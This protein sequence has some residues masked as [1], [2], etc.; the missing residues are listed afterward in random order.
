[1][2]FSSIIQ[3]AHALR[4][5]ER[6]SVEI[7]QEYLNR[8][9]A[10][11]SSLN[12]FITVTSEQ[13]LEAARL[14][15]EKRAKGLA[16]WLTGIPIVY[17]DNFC[18]QGVLTTCASRML[19][20][21]I[22]P[23]NAAVVERLKAAGVVILG[24]TNMDEFAM[25]ASNETSFY[26]PVKNPWNI[27]CV[28][29]GSSGGSAAAISAG[30]ATFG[31]GSDTGG[32]IRQP[33]A[34]CNLVGLKPTY[35]RISRYGMIA[36]ASSLDQAGPMTRTAEDAAYVMNVL[37]GVDNQDSTSLNTPVPDY[38]AT[39]NDSL[40]GLTIGVPKEFFEEGL[41]AA[42]AQRM[43]EAIRVYESLG[44]RIKNVSLK[45][46][47]QGITLYYLIASAECSSN[48]AR[49]DGI[50]YG[51]RCDQ[52]KDLEDLY[53]RSRSEGFGEEVKR[54][55]LLGT[56]ILSDKGYTYYAKAQ[57]ARAALIQEFEKV[58]KEVDILLGPT[59]PSPAFKIGEKMD[60]PF[61]MYLSDIYTVTISLAGLPAISLPAGFIDALPIGQQLI[62]PALSE[63]RLLNVAHRYQSVTDWHTQTPR[64]LS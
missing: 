57:A 11:D 17:K 53:T 26:G 27:G 18:T 60:D 54:R 31:M 40:E 8:I 37:A 13:A 61:H 41:S 20:N 2:Y 3:L 14:A 50:R 58:F 28:P 12:S 30:L 47:H 52:P 29:G 16:G 55:I 43:E 45:N 36:Y 39:L 56:H 32:S 10:I 59:T 24:K 64:D 6:S 21:F 35:G 48:L 19:S 62:G 15:D 63:A 7:T 4:K 5:K 46:T 34:L 22:P 44:A 38:T 42:I 25:G 23:Y 1:M 9:T 49:Y 51:Y 33:S